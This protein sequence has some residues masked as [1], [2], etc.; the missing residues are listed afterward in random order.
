MLNRLRAV[1]RWIVSLGLV[2]WLASRLDWPAVGRLLAGADYW[3]C[4]SAVFSGLILICGISG[5]LWL[6]LRWGGLVVPWATAWR[7]TWTGQ[8][9]NSVL[10]GSTGGDVYKIYEISRQLGARSTEGAAAVLADRLYALVALLGLAGIS[11]AGAGIPWLGFLGGNLTLRTGLLFVSGLLLTGL[12]VAWI[13]RRWLAGRSQ[14]LGRIIG[15]IEATFEQ[16]A[17]YF[18]RLRV[19]GLALLAAMVVHIGNFFVVFLLAR[20]LHL[21]LEF[22]DVLTLMPVL[23]LVLLLPVTVNGHGLREVVLVG[24]FSWLG[25]VRTGTGL[26]AREQAIALSVMLVACDLICNL[27][28]G[29]WS[30]WHRR[31]QTVTT[32]P[33]STSIPLS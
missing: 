16:V 18:L 24:Y 27:P 21:P 4:C 31:Q 25:T 15:L 2:A 5:R 13:A 10:P 14:T 3:L 17:G 23:M 20:A 19:L 29:F 33:S 7:V 1:L 26:G 11:A 28:G 9:L 30:L 8:F 32:L 12:S 22:F 6:M